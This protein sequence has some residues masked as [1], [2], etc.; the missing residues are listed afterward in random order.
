MTRIAYICA[1]PGIPEF[2][3]KGASIHVQEMLRALL[4]RGFDP[5]LFAVRLDGDVPM[6]EVPA[7]LAEMDVGV[8]LYPQLTDF[9]FSPLKIVEYMAAGLATIT[10]RVSGLEEMVEHEATG[11]LY[12]PDDAE[13]LAAAILR[14]RGDAK[15]SRR[16]GTE[17]RRRVLAGR[18][19]DRIAERILNRAGLEEVC[20]S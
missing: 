9:Y 20:L 15:L 12:A 11:L 8:A 13:A 3:S 2:G 5:V 4:R 6:D 1:D 16:L 14:L 10:S 18:T 19:W 17:G 7:L